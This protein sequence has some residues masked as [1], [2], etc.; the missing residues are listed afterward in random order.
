VDERKKTGPAD[1]AVLDPDGAFVRR[2]RDDRDALTELAS[3]LWSAPEEV[4]AV[5]LARIEALAH[6]LAGAA[7]TFGYAEIGAAAADLEGSVATNGPER[8]SAIDAG[9]VNLKAALGASA[10]N[11]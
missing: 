8:R 3:G 4:R 10:R 1:L 2:L 9:L 11:V 6:R 7:G 5:R